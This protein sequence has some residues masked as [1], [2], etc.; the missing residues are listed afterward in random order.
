MN[1]ERDCPVRAGD[2]FIP[3]RQCE[4]L[5]PVGDEISV[6][7]IKR[8]RPETVDR[9]HGIGSESDAVVLTA[10][11][12]VSRRIR[13]RTRIDRIFRQIGAKAVERDAGPVGVVG[14]IAANMALRHH[15]S[16]ALRGPFC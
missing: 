8:D 2:Q 16:C 15:P 9:R 14:A 3:V 12:C 1:V 10:L 5:R 4:A 6:L 7:V 13:A 11:Q